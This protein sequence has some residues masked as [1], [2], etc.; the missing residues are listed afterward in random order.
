MHTEIQLHG[1]AGRAVH[2]YEM[3]S[4]VGGHN[5]DNLQTATAPHKLRAATT[6]YKLET[7]TTLHNLKT[8]I[9]LHKLQTAATADH[10]TQ[11]QDG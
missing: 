8:A 6:L 7:T 3:H 1:V 4:P 9:T 5:C 10:S 11:T 2:A